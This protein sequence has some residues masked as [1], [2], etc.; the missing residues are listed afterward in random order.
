MRVLR[1]V[2]RIRKTLF[3]KRFKAKNNNNNNNDSNNNDKKKTT[4]TIIII[5][6]TII[7]IIMIRSTNNNN[8]YYYNYDDEWM[9]LFKAA[10]PI[11]L[12]F[13]I[14]SDKGKKTKT[15]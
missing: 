13:D 8:Y 3:V 12:S 14:V 11:M 1:A 4:T 2:Q 6:I 9:S 15:K 10:S 7:T 5:I